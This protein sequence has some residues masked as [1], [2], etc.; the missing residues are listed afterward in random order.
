MNGWSLLVSRSNLNDAGIVPDDSYEAAPLSPGEALLK[1]Q[2]FAFTANNITY[3]AMGE[4]LYWKFFPAPT[5]YGKLPVWGFAV[6][7]GSNAAGL[8]VGR[9]LRGY[10]PLA[11][12]LRVQ[13]Q[14][15]GNH[16]TDLTPHR[17]P[18][19]VFYNR[20]PLV[21]D[22]EVDGEDREVVLLFGTS[23]LLDD[24][25]AENEALGARAV[26][27]VGASSKTA[28]GTAF[29]LRQRGV[30]TIGITSA[31]HVPFVERV[32][33]YDTVVSYGDIAGTPFTTPF[34]LTDFA[35]NP[36]TLRAIYARYRDWI[37]YTATVG[38]THWDAS[39][40]M[41][42]LAGPEPRLFF[43]PERVTKRMSDWGPAT[44][45]TKYANAWRTFTGDLSRWLEIRYED[46]PEGALRTYQA[47]LAGKHGP[48]VGQMVR[49][50]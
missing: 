18:L 26:V 24:F 19:P 32:G 49:L 47:M 37:V 23:F 12:H 5:G 10:L 46:G 35:G 44:F 4:Q 16:V 7:V 36:D 33:Y 50:S 39:T 13:P 3:A 8:E 38:R 15:T 17:A 40:D 42:G 45:G 43:A 11:S 21:S 27:I 1:V 6:V 9:R 41:S 34:F 30:R 25:V 28:I 14:V 22:T 48:E 29:L 31:K 2:K 20:Y